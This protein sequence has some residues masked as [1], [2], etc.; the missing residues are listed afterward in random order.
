MKISQVL[1]KSFFLG[2]PHPCGCCGEWSRFY[3]IGLGVA[4]L[5][6]ALDRKEARI[7]F[8]EDPVKP[9]FPGYEAPA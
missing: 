4:D 7:C 2:Y 8:E 5:E 3:V 1:E 9:A 6:M